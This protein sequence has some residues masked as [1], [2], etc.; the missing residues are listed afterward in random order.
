MAGL[1]LVALDSA[2]AYEAAIVAVEQHVSGS[3]AIYGAVARRFNASLV[4]WDRQQADRL[5][6]AVNVLSVGEALAAG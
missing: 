3:D 1:V 6:S 4:T 2:I 5:R